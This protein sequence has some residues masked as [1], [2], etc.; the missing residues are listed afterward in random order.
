MPVSMTATT[1]AELPPV[2]ACASG[3]WILRVFHC[4]GPVTGGAADTKKGS[5]STTG[6]FG[7]SPGVAAADAPASAS[8][9]DAN[10]ATR[11]A[12]A[13]DAVDRKG[14]PLRYLI[15]EAP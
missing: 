2:T 11:N 12:R 7:R 8:A 15:P 6:A 1:T 10:S 4:P 14:F 5:A 13:T 3:A 9:A